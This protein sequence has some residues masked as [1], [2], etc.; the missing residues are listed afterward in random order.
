MRTAPDTSNQP[1]TVVTRRV[2]ARRLVTGTVA[3]TVPTVAGAATC[4][5]PTTKPPTSL[6]WYSWGPE[7]PLPFTAGPGLNTRVNWMQVANQFA[8]VASGASGNTIP[9][10]GTG[11]ATPVPTDKL[12]EQQ[13][14]GF[15]AE[16]NGL[17]VKVSTERFDRYHEKLSTFAAAGMLPD[18]IAYDGAN[19]LPLLKA[20]A[21]YPLQRL[22]GSTGLAFLAGY[23]PGYI[24]SSMYR[25]R[26][27][28]LPYQ[29]RNL[30]LYVNKSMFS[31]MSL[32]PSTWGTPDWTWARFLEVAG[33]LTRRV[34]GGGYRQMGTLLTGRPFWASLIRQNGAA[35]FSKDLSRSRYAEPVVHEALQWASDLVWRYGVAPSEQQNPNGQAFTFDG[36]TVAMWVWY[37]HAIP[38]LSTRNLGF[39]WD[40]YP[41]PS[42][43]QAATYADWSFV[44]MNTNTT[45]VDAAWDLMRYLAGPD[46]DQRALRTGIAAPV[47]RGSEVRF[48]TGAAATR[49][50]AAAIQASQQPLAVRPLHESWVQLTGLIDYYLRPVWTGQERA[51][52]A[53]RDLSKAL[54][55]V[56]NGIGLGGPAIGNAPDGA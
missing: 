3:A 30:V 13:I 49:N 51:A 20:G 4:G 25:G 46:G 33:Q 53:A 5:H 50:R 47:V 48:M 44:S 24:E 21:L 43:R 36:G 32:P 54:D 35:E 37:Q 14:E 10:P 39:E 17:T 40:V 27:Y 26:L 56:L 12:L 19:A 55:A 42:S 1:E 18:V 23:Q 22:Q 31:G 6:T 16:R 38:L 45:E 52:Y 9:T 2:F 15:V 41:L 29:A 8:A 34:A 11:S 7:Y 28:G